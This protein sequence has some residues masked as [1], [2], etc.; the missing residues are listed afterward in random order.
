[1]NQSNQEDFQKKIKIR[2]HDKKLLTTALTHSSY[3]MSGNFPGGKTMNGWSFWETQ[4]WN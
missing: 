1:M 3:A 4:C 2:F